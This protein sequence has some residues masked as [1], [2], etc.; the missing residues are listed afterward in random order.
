MKMKLPVDELQKI[1][2]LIAEDIILTGK[3]CDVGVHL[4]GNLTL[5]EIMAVLFFSV[6]NL[7]PDHPD[8][9]DRDRIILSKGHGNVALSSAMA[10]RGFFP[11]SELEKFDTFNS[12]LSMHIDKHRMPGVEISSGSLGHGLS[13][14]VGA[15]LGGKI[16]HAD[17]RVYCIISDGELMEGSTWE[18]ILSAGHF[19][20]DNLTVI[21]D[22]N[23]FTIEGATENNI[24]LEP[25]NEKFSAFN[26]HVIEV[27]GH[28]I[29]ALLKAFEEETPE[30]KPKMII[31]KT[32]KGRGIPSVEGK[33]SSHFFRIKP[34][35][36]DEALRLLKSS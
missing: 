21:V 16:D 32:I 22:R 34:E 29:D 28:D 14:A 18:A 10:R 33:A 7:D 27:D 11:L 30:N 4:G 3:N 1:S 17:W 25:L 12:M 5:T 13:I 24:A 35:D 19:K 20:L 9:E 31:A 26:W 2:K 15:A 23:M 8:W 6:A 36:A